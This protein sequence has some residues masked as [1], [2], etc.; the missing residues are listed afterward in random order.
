MKLLPLLLL[1]G[2]MTDIRLLP[3]QPMPETVY[4]P[5]PLFDEPQFYVGDVERERWIRHFTAMG[6]PRAQ[7]VEEAETMMKIR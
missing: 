2:C 6:L 5:P 3:R 1:P 7:A 4:D